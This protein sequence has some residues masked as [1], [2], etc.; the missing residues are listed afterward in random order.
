MH[1][2]VTGRLTTGAVLRVFA[3]IPYSEHG[4]GADLDFGS[5][6]TLRPSAL[7]LL[8]NPGQVA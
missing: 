7:R 3:G 4:I 1:L 6:T 5:T 2:S 8:A